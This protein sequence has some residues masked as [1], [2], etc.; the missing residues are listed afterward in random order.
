MPIPGTNSHAIKNAD[1]TWD[2]LDVPI[3]HDG[4]IDRYKA[5]GDKA[6]T[7]ITGPEWFRHV[8]A[9]HSR[10]E[11]AG[12]LGRAFLD[13][14]T[15][16]GGSQPDAGYIKPHRVGNLTVEGEKKP[17]LFADILSIPDAF[18]QEWVKSGRLAGR[19]IESLVAENGWIDG[20][21]LMPTKVPHYSLP[22][23]T[24][25]RESVSGET[26]DATQGAEMAVACASSAHARAAIARLETPPMADKTI[27]VSGTMPDGRVGSWNLST[28]L[29]LAE[30]KKD[31]D[32]KPEIKA[33][34]EGGEEKSG[35]GGGEGDGWKAKLDAL[36]GC[37]IP[38]EDIP[39]VVAGI[40]EFASSLETPSAEESMIE[41]EEPSV[42]DEEQVAEQEDEPLAAG[43]VAERAIRAEAT[44][45][46]AKAETAELRA[47]MNRD[48]AVAAAVIRMAPF[49]IG[50]DPEAVLL[51]RYKK[52]G[53]A[54]MEIFVD[55]TE[56]TA[57]RSSGAGIDDNI[58][59][60]QTDELP[61]E[62]MAITSPGDREIALKANREYQASIAAGFDMTDVSL[63][64][65]INR[66]IGAAQK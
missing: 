43:K 31:D 55:T 56:K 47:E 15:Q 19:S 27:T 57:P 48:K 13:H 26:R 11:K 33:E 44:A 49:N 40:T 29:L 3:V 24:I 7:W 62:V 64:S 54:G 50:S 65:H 58:P 52:D 12:R 61:A 30:E 34:D 8:I 16:E 10:E 9:V 66:A 17:A 42:L 60:E 20:L 36:K 28:A 46:A 35:D 51:A 22:I 25:G 53:A 59:G 38:V 4:E 32:G 45:I 21:A 6:D 18:Y 23:L 5:N 39:A 14:H 37:D 63:A 2:V 41:E 1:G